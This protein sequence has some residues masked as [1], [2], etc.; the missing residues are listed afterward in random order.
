MARHALTRTKQITNVIAE[1]L[2]LARAMHRPPMT[3][4]NLSEI[5]A[6]LIGA[7]FYTNSISKIE[8][9]KRSVYDFE[10]IAFAQALGVT[11]DWLLGLSDQGGLELPVSTIAKRAK[12][13]LAQKVS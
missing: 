2:R 11:S 5:V 7:E 6:D 12:K 1:R 3:Q 8:S 9:G 4:E 13:Q 10:V